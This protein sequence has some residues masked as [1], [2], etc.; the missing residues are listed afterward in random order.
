MA[1]TSGGQ[2]SRRPFL[3]TSSR[4]ASPQSRAAVQA[5]AASG[6][7]VQGFASLKAG[8]YKSAQQKLE[9]AVKLA[10][11]DPA[12]HYYLGY[13]YYLLSRESPGAG[14]YLS[15]AAEEIAQSHRLN[16]TFKPGWAKED[17]DRK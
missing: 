13:T 11:R 17:A 10:P 16:P 15:K 1:A 5:P 4:G 7:F 2:T 9:R 8:H 6:A 3:S 12:A 14:E